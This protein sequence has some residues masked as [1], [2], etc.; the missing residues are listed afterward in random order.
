MRRQTHLEAIRGVAAFIVV[1]AHFAAAFYPSALFGNKYPFH[2]HWESLFTTTPLGLL[3]AGHFAVCVFFV[4]SG[5]VLSWPYFGDT[6]KDTVHL[7][8][9]MLKRPFRLGGLV[10]ASVLASFFLYRSACYFN[11]PVSIQSYSIPWFKDF[12]PQNTFTLERLIIDVTTRMFSAGWFYNSPLWTLQIELYG[13]FITF[14]FLLLFRKSNLRPLAY[15]YTFIYFHGTLYHGFIIGI[16]LADIV[17]T[18][19]HRVLKWSRSTIAWPLFVVG[20]LFSS[21]PEYIVNKTEL[22]NTFYGAFPNLPGLGGGYSMLGAAFVFSSVL[23]SPHLQKM[24]SGRSLAFL[25]RISY[26]V[27]AFHFLLLG[28]FTSWLFLIFTHRFT[29]NINCA[30]VGI[31]SL[32]ALLLLSYWLTKYVDEPVTRAANR[33]ASIWLRS[34]DAVAYPHTDVYTIA[35]GLVRRYGYRCKLTRCLL[36]RRCE[37][38][39]STRDT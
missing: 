34:T 13:S 21:Y 27:Y 8:A 33:L 5:Y 9:A 25:G 37:T 32:S 15:I 10:L 35:K 22:T 18:Y 14:I 6:S 23:L 31:I 36:R 29:Y 3:V 1:L 30:L 12:W 24:L 2:E 28:S 19:P 26:A 39:A 11:G 7:L 16:L 38:K 4:L 17:R 20:L